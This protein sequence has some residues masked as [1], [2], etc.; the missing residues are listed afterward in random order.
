MAKDL[1]NR[2]VW[3]VDT[4]Y[5]AKRITF[6]EINRRWVCTDMSGGEDMPLRTFHNYRQAI[7]ELFDINI[8]CQRKGGYHYYIENAD[9][10]EGG[11]VRTWLLNTLTVSNIINESHDLKRRILFEEI[12]SGR[13]YLSPIIEAM[14]DGLCLE[15]TYKSYWKENAST[16]VVEPYCVKVFRQRWYMVAKSRFY[17]SVAIYSLDRISEL[18]QSGDTYV[19]PDDFDPHEYFANTFGIIAHDGTN[20]ETVRLLVMGKEADYIRALP[21]H[22]SQKEIE[23]RSDGSVFEYYIKPTFDFCQELLS[24]GDRLEV[25]APEWLRG[26]IASVA[27]SMTAMYFKPS[28]RFKVTR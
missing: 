12:P 7:E 20:P 18:E 4:I 17:G 8:E 13:E 25:L 14:R 22:S 5:R 9:D 21:L 15:I 19:Y 28:G 1:L 16:F 26:Q 27:G 24:H 3:L 11:G 2:Y 6:E 23:K 10:M